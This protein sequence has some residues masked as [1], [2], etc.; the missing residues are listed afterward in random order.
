MIERMRLIITPRRARGEGRVLA[1][2]PHGLGVGADVERRHVGE[3]PQVLRERRDPG[4]LDLLPF[5]LFVEDAA[6]LRRE[7]IQERGL[8]A[9]A[10]RLRNSCFD[11]VA[12]PAQ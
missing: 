10:G 4:E 5:V 9:A 7:P 3:V 12:A 8:I 6:R 11:R 2:E 1:Q